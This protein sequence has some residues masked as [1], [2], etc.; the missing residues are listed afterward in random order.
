MY[1]TRGSFYFFMALWLLSLFAV[2]IQLTLFEE[3]RVGCCC[4]RLLD[5]GDTR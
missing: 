1:E 4:V 2:A 5:L 3:V